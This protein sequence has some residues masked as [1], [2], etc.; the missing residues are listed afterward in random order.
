ML[1]TLNSASELKTASGNVHAHSYSHETSARRKV[2]K[3]VS[4]TL[5]TIAPKEVDDLQYLEID[6]YTFFDFLEGAG[7]IGNADTKPLNKLRD[8]S[9]RIASALSTMVGWDDIYK[10]LD[11]DHLALHHFRWLDI[12]LK[13][14]LHGELCTDVTREGIT[15]FMFLVHG[16]DRFQEQRLQKVIEDVKLRRMTNRYVKIIGEA[17][18][19][20][21]REPLP[22]FEPTLPVPPWPIDKE[23]VDLTRITKREGTKHEA[24]RKFQEMHPFVPHKKS[25]K[26]SL[27]T[28][29]PYLNDMENLNVFQ[30]LYSNQAKPRAYSQAVLNS[31]LAMELDTHCSFKPTL[32]A[33]PP[34]LSPRSERAA[35][36]RWGD[37]HVHI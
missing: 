11:I 22:S 23:Y 18:A 32:G 34:F 5:R 9:F 25:S 27:S 14:I 3:H 37:D 10:T 15:A 30:R 28:S 33:A 36:A 4:D 13:D 6:R 16:L 12:S 8:L 20:E 24:E 1:A 17:A 26:I 29:N 7:V 35:T 2:V 19:S 31:S 21:K